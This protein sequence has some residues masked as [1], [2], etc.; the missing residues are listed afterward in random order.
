MVDTGHRILSAILKWALELPKAN[1][2][3]AKSA[4][5]RDSQILW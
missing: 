1:L 5:G 4:I 3:T 2:L